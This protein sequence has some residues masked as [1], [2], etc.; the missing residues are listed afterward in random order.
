MLGLVA[1][2][3][4]AQAAKNVLAFLG[5]QR[6]TLM[7]GWGLRAALGGALASALGMAAREAIIG[8]SSEAAV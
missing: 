5:S 3:Y 7:T 2:L 8:S 6:A 1:A 4:M